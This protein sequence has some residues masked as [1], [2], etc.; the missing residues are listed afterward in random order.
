MSIPYHLIKTNVVVDG[1]TRLPMGS[2]AHVDE[3]KRD[4]AKD[5]H[6]IASLG[7]RLMDSTK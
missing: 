6:R 5:V 4:L 1:L 7:V 3:E 2:N